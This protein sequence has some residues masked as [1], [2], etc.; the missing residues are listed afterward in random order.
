MV[1]TH[2]DELKAD[3]FKLSKILATYKVKLS[4]QQ[5]LDVLSR[6]RFNLAYEALLSKTQDST[7]GKH[8]TKQP[9]SQ[10]LHEWLDCAT[11]FR[12]LFNTLSTDGVAW[13]DW[14]HESHEGSYWAGRTY[15]RACG[16]AAERFSQV[17]EGF[18]QS[19]ESITFPGL[20]FTALATN[21]H[22]QGALATM[23]IQ[24][25]VP[26]KRDD[27][28]GNRFIPIGL[29]Q[30]TSEDLL[31]GAES[32][33]VLRPALPLPGIESHPYQPSVDLTYEVVGVDALKSFAKVL[34]KSD[35]QRIW[36]VVGIFDVETR[37]LISTED[38]QDEIEEDWTTDADPDGKRLQA[39]C[40]RA[41]RLSYEE[42]RD[43]PPFL[44]LTRSLNSTNTQDDLNRSFLAICAH[45]SCMVGNSGGWDEAFQATAVIQSID[46]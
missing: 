7:E 8:V 33:V 29:N 26:S 37:I 24:S 14:G 41:C 4:S 5:C 13:A 6:L 1:R 21:L 27:S 31:Y 44:R 9:A 32:R 10:A 11:S 12:D 19:F 2:V 34:K 43:W 25:L 3:A 36:A 22:F 46:R 28:S 23:R 40:K 45:A 39:F 20:T 18:I 30:K 15:L 35:I 16:V 38:G 17:A 42:T